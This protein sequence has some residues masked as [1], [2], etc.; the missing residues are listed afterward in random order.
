MLS[1][2]IVCCCCS[3]ESSVHRPWRTKSTTALTEGA[4]SSERQMMASG[5]LIM[6]ASLAFSYAQPVDRMHPVRPIRSLFHPAIFVSIL[7]QALIHLYCMVAAV[8]MST[9]AMGP[10]LLREVKQ[11]HK[12]HKN[13]GDGSADDAAPPHDE[14]DPLAA[15]TSLW[16]APFM[17]NLLN[18]VVFLV[19]TSQMIAVLFVNY[20]GRPWMKGLLENQPLFLSVVASI[21]G[22][23]VAAWQMVPMANKAI[24]LFEF[25]DDAFRH[26]VVHLVLLSLFG[27]F[28]WDRLC[29]AVFAP[30]IFKAMAES[31]RATTLQDL[32]PLAQTI[33]KVCVAALLLSQGNILVLIGAYWMYS[34]RAQAVAADVQA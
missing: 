9:A 25:P 22:L 14:D 6:T 20:K 32:V 28:V 13:W 21:G 30:T 3:A 2:I 16:S 11:F 5:W 17:P 15:L 7:G 1:S 18:T 29:T 26:R 8:Q 10:E 31:G 27:S 34:K 33:A 19:E 23:V 12:K 24:H 4:R